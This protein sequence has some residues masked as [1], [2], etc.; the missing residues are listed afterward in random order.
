MDDVTDSSA[1]A[2]ETP[3]M[4]VT[5]EW[6]DAG[7]FESDHIQLKGAGA[8]KGS[9]LAASKKNDVGVVS[10]SR[11]GSRPPSISIASAVPPVRTISRSSDC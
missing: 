3:E 10:S 5:R 6:R 7:E 11:F 8:R 1:S 2:N 9:P 4:A